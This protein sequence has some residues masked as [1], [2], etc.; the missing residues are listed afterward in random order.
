[1][2]FTQLRAILP[3]VLLLGLAGSVPPVVAQGV[4]APATGVEQ[5]SVRPP[6][7]APAPEGSAP[8]N[9][10]RSSGSADLWRTIRRGDQGRV[11]IPNEN[12]AL[13]IQSEGDNWRT[14]RNGPYF[15]YLGWIL[16]GSIGLLAL[17]FA[18][19]GRVRLD[20]GL[21][22][23]RIRRFKAIERF[24]HWVTAISF[25]VLALTGLNLVFGRA[26]LIPVIGKDAFA[27][28]TFW[29]KYSHN[30]TAFAFMLGLALLFLLF[31]L[32]NFPNRHDVVWLLR[33]GGLLGGGHPPAR[34][35]NAGQKILFWLVILLG[36]SLSLSGL[37]LMFPYRFTFFESTFQ[38]LNT[39]FGLSLPTGLEPI[40]EQQLAA[41]WHGAVGAVMTALILG[42]IYIGTLGMEGAFSAMGDGT[43]DLNWAREHHNLWVAE[44][45]RRGGMPADD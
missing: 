10:D 30:Y 38:A 19:R 2:R 39:L 13:L 43:V 12:A 32:Q 11:T 22:G 33:G 16:L 17:F 3:L 7:G 1:M 5:P 45:E 26:L 31:V 29:G 24:A 35:F 4:D 42:H 44:M 23:I 14:V 41:L 9:I 37:E 20:S 21:S 6:E 36:L 15:T 25:V 27:T 40:H 18:A 8:V 34:K 28:I